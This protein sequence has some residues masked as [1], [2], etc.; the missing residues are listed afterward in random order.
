MLSTDNITLFDL[1]Q[2]IKE[3]LTQSFQSNFWVIAEISEV[4]ENSSGHCYLELV[5]KDEIQDYPKA[6][7]R[8]TIWAYT[9]R[10]LK[11]YFETTTGRPLSSGIKIL[12]SVQVVFHE[13]F[14]YSLNITDIEPRF[15]IGDIEQK[16]RETIERLVADGVFD[17][18]KGHYL[19]ML[20]KR[21]AV[22]SS[23]SAAGLQDFVNQLQ[24]NSYGYKIEHTLFSASMQGSLAEESI[25]AALNSINEQYQKYDMV[26]LIRGGG[27]QTDL[28]CFDSYWLASHVAQFPLPVITGIGHDKD[29]SVVDLVA[30][31]KLKTPTAVAEFILNKFIEAESIIVDLKERLQLLVEESLTN[32]RLQF[33]KKWTSIVPMVLQEISNAEISIERL[34]GQLLFSSN[35]FLSVENSNIFKSVKTFELASLMKISKYLNGIG[36]LKSS[37]K[38]QSFRFIENCSNYIDKKSDSNTSLDPINVLKRGYSIT[39]HNGKIIKDSNLVEKGELLKTILNKGELESKVL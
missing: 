32:Q 33:E 20:P 27:S 37:L 28:A 30:H 38:N 16:R 35:Q 23:P 24:S 19:P 1:H 14:G 21:I 26:V 15:T 29:I 34:S 10:M 13:V 17:M 5:Q 12:V 22:I 2:K 25:I 11:P 36:V 7:A 4:K 8:A 31:T 9:Y 39:L 18:N 3:A 6:K